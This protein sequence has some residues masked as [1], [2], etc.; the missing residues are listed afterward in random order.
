MDRLLNTDVDN[1]LHK[2]RGIMSLRGIFCSISG[3]VFFLL[4]F[5]HHFILEVVAA[6][7]AAVMVVVVVKVSGSI[8][9][10]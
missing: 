5:S 6:A 4:F 8:R 9:G 1:Y 3:K 7:V 10:T 2:I